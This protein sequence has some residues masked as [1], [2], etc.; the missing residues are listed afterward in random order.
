MTG[1]TSCP[2]SAPPMSGACGPRSSTCTGWG[3]GGSHWWTAAAPTPRRWSARAGRRRSRDWV[4][5]R[6][7]PT[8]PAGNSAPGRGWEPG[9]LDD[10]FDRFHA[11]GV[12]AALC[13]GDEDTLAINQHARRRGRAVPDDLSIVAYDD[14]LVGMADPPLTAVAPDKERVGR[15]RRTPAARTHRWCERGRHGA[16]ARPAHPHPAAAGRPRL[17]RGPDRQLTH[18]LRPHRS[19]REAAQVRHTA[20]SRIP[21]PVPASACVA[22]AS[23]LHLRT[24]RVDRAHPRAFRAHPP[25]PYSSADRQRR[26]APGATHSFSPGNPE[27]PRTR[28]PETSRGRT[29]N[30]SPTTP[31]ARRHGDGAGRRR[32]GDRLFQ[33]RL[34][35]RHQGRCR[36]QDRHQ[37]R[38]ASG[39]HETR[40][41]QGLPRRREAVRDRQPGHHDQAHRRRVGPAVIRDQAGRW[42]TPRPSSRCR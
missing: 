41:A 29:S 19:D 5:P 13:H 35:R 2:R 7:C 33:Q 23:A 37:R 22:P 24:P 36:R 14:E 4:C 25:P 9:V 38:G 21:P 17:G 20:S 12:T 1:W 40:A 34:G 30:E 16:A 8:C 3:T 6:T 18:R 10:L 11:Y 31:A 39:H 32:A 15:G 28:T 26:S 42:Q 27:A